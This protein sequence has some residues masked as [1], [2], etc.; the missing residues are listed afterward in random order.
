MEFVFDE[1]NM[2]NL[3][4]RQRLDKVIHVLKDGN[5]RDE[6][7]RWDCIWLA[8]EIT[9]AVNKDDPI[10]T[11]IADLMVWVLNNDDN[12]IVRHE[13]AFQIGLHNLRTK[14]PDLINSILNDKSDLVKHE[15]IEALGLLRDHGS[16]ETLIKMLEDKGVAVSE[17]A[18]FVLKRLERLKDRGEYKGEAIL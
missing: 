3:P 17:T 12:G 13:A 11:E 18:S 2:R 1:Y 15:A 4:P 14:I 9:E 10:C 8:G 16:K 6:S 5:E 7:I